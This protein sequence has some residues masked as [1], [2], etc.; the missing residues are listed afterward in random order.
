MQWRYNNT[1]MF[2]C[3]IQIDIKQTGPCGISMS[4]KTAAN[5]KAKL[6]AFI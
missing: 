5:R 6:A 4:T 1:I 2:I 3:K